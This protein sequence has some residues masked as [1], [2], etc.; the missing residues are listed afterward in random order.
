MII[1]ILNNTINQFQIICMY[2]DMYVQPKKSKY[3][4]ELHRALLLHHRV[5][6]QKP[7]RILI[8]YELI[9]DFCWFL[10]VNL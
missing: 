2:V 4:S 10:I 7:I 3:K 6:L 8:C 9:F 5:Q 1:I